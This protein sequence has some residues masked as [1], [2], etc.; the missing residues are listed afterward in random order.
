MADA[1][2]PSIVR[3]ATSRSGQA[4]GGGECFDLVD[5]ALRDA[6]ARSA[7]HYG[8]VTPDADYVWGRSVTLGALRAGDVLQFRNYVASYTFTRTT[9]FTF[10]DGSTMDVPEEDTETVNRPHHSAIVTGSAAGGRTPVIEQ[11]VDRG[12]GTMERTVGTARLYLQTIAQRTVRTTASV[13]IDA[14]WLTRV[15]RVTSDPASRTALNTIYQSN[16]GRNAQAA[17]TETSSVTVR[18]TVRAYRPQT[19]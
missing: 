10:A 13:P 17:I 16:R 2:G 3:F 18:G 5:A 14:A 1:N 8:R 7:S 11:N 6:G 15:L 19:P 12:S 4:V 9:A